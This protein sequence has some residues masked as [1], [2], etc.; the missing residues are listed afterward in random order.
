MNKVGFIGG[1]A[2]AESIVRGICGKIF[3]P[4]DIFISEIRSARCEEL[5]KRYGVNAVE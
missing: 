2:L 5:S 3:A 1:G 4:N